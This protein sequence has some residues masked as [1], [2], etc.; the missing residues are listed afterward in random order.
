M[1]EHSLNKKILIYKDIF[2]GEKSYQEDSV[3]FISLAH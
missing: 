2:L 1:K 3:D